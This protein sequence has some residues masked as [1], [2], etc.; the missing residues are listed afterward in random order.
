MPKIQNRTLSIKSDENN[1]TQ[2]EIIITPYVTKKKKRKKNY[3]FV[4][5]ISYL[6]QNLPAVIQTKTTSFAVTIYR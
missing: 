4:I 1:N 3:L 5:P 6:Q 2:T